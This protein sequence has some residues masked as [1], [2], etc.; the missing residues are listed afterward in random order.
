MM[1]DPKMA[2]LFDQ[3]MFDRGFVKAPPD[4]QGKGGRP[5]KSEQEIR[6]RHKVYRE[7]Q[8]R[9]AGDNDDSAWQKMLGAEPEEGEA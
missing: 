7:E 8:K 3:M 1:N 6:N 5:T 2:E 4:R 9:L